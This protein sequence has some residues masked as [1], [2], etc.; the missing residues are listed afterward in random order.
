[1]SFPPPWKAQH[2]LDSI[3]K[4]QLPKKTG[5]HGLLFNTTDLSYVLIKW[6]CFIFFQLV[7]KDWIVFLYFTFHLPIPFKNLAALCVAHQF[8]CPCASFNCYSTVKCFSCDIWAASRQEA[9]V[10]VDWQVEFVPVS[11]P[12]HPNTITAQRELVGWEESDRLCIGLTCSRF[13]RWII[14]LRVFL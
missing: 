3:R 2:N 4:N 7:P 1:M 6:L 5:H 12:P 13:Y 8:I 10:L 9:T 14:S 11:P